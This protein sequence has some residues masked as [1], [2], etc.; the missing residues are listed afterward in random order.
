MEA[1]ETYPDKC[2]VC[3][4]PKE[5]QILHHVCVANLRLNGV[6]AKPPDCPFCK[7]ELA[8]DTIRVRHYKCQVC[9]WSGF[10]TDLPVD[11]YILLGEVAHHILETQTQIAYYYL[12]GLAGHPEFGK[13]LRYKD[14][15]SNY[16]EVWIHL[17][18][19]Q[20]F[21]KRIQDWRKASE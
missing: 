11:G 8:D 13:G 16:H 18:D 3:T 4:W 21:T 10:Y 20:E 5:H 15:E 14:H 2:R 9:G 6:C 17:D 1:E 7:N 19:V 12:K